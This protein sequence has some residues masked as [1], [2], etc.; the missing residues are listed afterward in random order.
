MK[1]KARVDI[2]KE[3]INKEMNAMR[4]QTMPSYG[5][6]R[7]F[8]HKG[9]NVQSPCEQKP[10]FMCLKSRKKMVW[11][12][13]GDQSRGKPISQKHSVIDSIKAR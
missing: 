10:S 9:E 7:Q 13:S 2:S 4:D 11:K 3:M 12:W 5:G 1:G 8:Q 6:S